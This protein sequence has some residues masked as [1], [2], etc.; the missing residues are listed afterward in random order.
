[1]DPRALSRVRV[2]VVDDDPSMRSLLAVW[3]GQALDVAPEITQAGTV[4][5]LVDRWQSARPDVVLIDQ[6]LPDGTGLDGVR[7]L[8]TEDPDVDVVLL[9]GDDDPGLDQAAERAGV[10][11]FLLKSELSARSL[12]RCLRYIV[13]RR[14]DSRALQRSE[15]RYRNLVGSL[16]DTG[17]IVL[18]RDL[19]FVLAE[20]EALQRAGWDGEA[21]RGGDPAEILG[22]DG[23]AELLEHYRAA[24]AG[25]RRTVPFTAPDGRTYRTQFAP[26]REDGRSVTA[27][28]A[29][30]VDV[31][32]QLRQDQA[33]RDS[34][35]RFQVAFD[36][37]PV[38]MAL[39]GLDGRF[40]Q[41]NAALCEMVAMPAERLRSMSPFEIVHPDDAERV[42]TA[43]AALR[44]QTPS[45]DLEHRFV[46][47]HGNTVW[48]HA[49][50]TLI[51]DDSGVAL[52]ALAH[53]QDVTERRRY[54]AELHHQANHDPL[55]GL[56]NRRGFKLALD[57][58]FP[59]GRDQFCGALL[60]ADFDG[61]KAI[62]DTLG[63]AAG[64]QLLIAFATA[65]RER[66]RETDV[67][68]RLGGDEFAVLLA[69][70][71]QADA[72]AVAAAIG[73][74]VQTR[75]RSSAG[76]HQAFT[77]SVGVAMLDRPDGTPQDALAVADA[78]MY[79]AKKT[80]K[81]RYAVH[82]CG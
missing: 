49:Q 26:L 71:H 7:T 68:A 37:A 16:P 31:T 27:A 34:E 1:L 12:G 78:A 65:L 69:D 67:I 72:E 74:D 19:R 79:D 77:V 62:N 28:M 38:G 51:C 3:L 80:G 21:L 36:R 45:L 44:P 29:V 8:L 33:L 18:D 48:A 56:L 52:H 24:L 6:H 59:P 53:V 73:A 60:V 82:L 15:A 9:T 22:S 40:S 46:D 32:E 81:D 41:V 14:A 35:Q 10:A 64:D 63:H 17:V 61:F 43:F 23:H 58:Q 50:I 30:T 2:L 11:D 75:A 39:V 25:E 20:G 66:L 70:V 76:L 47:G 5:G 4:A 42:Q 54:E 57:E 55:T 13:R